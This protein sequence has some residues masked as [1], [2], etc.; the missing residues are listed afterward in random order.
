MAAL[1]AHTPGCKD[2]HTVVYI[3]VHANFSQVEHTI[4]FVQSYRTKLFLYDF[5]PTSGKE[6]LIAFYRSLALPDGCECSLLN[7]GVHELITELVG[8]WPK[9]VVI[10]L[11][12][13]PNY[14]FGRTQVLFFT[15]LQRAYPDL[16]K[17]VYVVGHCI[18]GCE[19]CQTSDKHGKTAFFS[20][21]VRGELPLKASS[22]IDT[23]VRIKPA[24][25][26][27]SLKRVLLAPSYGTT[28]ILSN[29]AVAEALVTATQR[30]ADVAVLAKFHGV[31]YAGRAHPLFQLSS[32]EYDTAALLQRSFVTVGEEAF[33][34]LPFME[35]SHLLI[36]DLNS[37]VP[38]EGLFFAESMIVFAYAPPPPYRPPVDA[39]YHA[40]LHIFRTP[41]ELV[42]LLAAFASGQLN[43]SPRGRAFFEQKKGLMSGNE[44]ADIAAQRGWH[45]SYAGP[46]PDA[47]RL[48]CIPRDGAVY[49][50]AI[51]PDE[52]T[53]STV[54]FA[55][56]GLEIPDSM[57]PY[58]QFLLAHQI[59]LEAGGVP[60]ELWHRVFA[61]ISQETFDAGTCFTLGAYSDGSG[62]LV[63]CTAPNGIARH[64]D[65]WLI[66]HAWTTTAER[67]RQVLEGNVPLQ[68]RLAQMMSLEPQTDAD[69]ARAGLVDRLVSDG[70]WRHAQTYTMRSSDG[71]AQPVW[72][73]MDELGSALEHCTDDPAV[74]VMPFLYLDK[75]LAYSLM[76]PRRA[77]ALGEEVTRD[78]CP[79]TA[80]DPLAHAANLLAWF[81]I[82][83]LAAGDD[84]LAAGAAY[85]ERLDAA[86][87]QAQL[88]G[89]AAPGAPLTV[90]DESTGFGSAESA[91]TGLKVC[92]PL[93][94]IRDHMSHARIGAFTD[95]WV[96]ADLI[97]LP[98]D[99]RF[100]ALL[101]P[102][103]RV[104]QFPHEACLTVKNRLAALVGHTRGSNVPW[105]P[106]SYDLETD[107]AA[108]CADYL[109]RAAAGRDNTWIVK[110][111]NLGRSEDMFVTRSLARILRSM[112]TV[113]R[114]VC[115]YIER[116][117]LYDGRKF[118]MRY[119]VVVRRFEPLEAYVYN[120]FWLRLANE[121][122]ALEDFA[123][124]ERHFTVMNYT[125]H[126]RLTQLLYR[127][128]VARWDSVL[129][130]AHPWYSHMQPQVNAC[131]RQ[132]F[133]SAASVPPP[134][135]L[136]GHGSNPHCAAM[137]GM[138]VMIEISD[139]GDIMRPVLLECNF[140]P[141]CTRAV[142]PIYAPTFF[143]DLLAVMFLERDANPDAWARV[144]AI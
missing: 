10:C 9:R 69:G 3:P 132:L 46:A 120:M 82:D 123:N 28:S 80:A 75:A 119:I 97:W 60:Q 33:N 21:Y 15:H 136:R 100:F 35:A 142:M 38:F 92:T 93:Q 113:P 126:G 34:I 111:W 4:E 68:Q 121:Q 40:H 73:V 63:Q 98:T 8:E 22:V 125:G 99:F 12:A 39:E 43:P 44:A 70:F 58:V 17:D 66:D 16:I 114:L 37:S 96:T 19:S 103:Q 85:R 130:P 76:W 137:Y 57:G 13:S 42:E 52:H 26:P 62:F 14:E 55:A 56:L 29:P 88:P 20:R 7:F 2:P 30:L 72:Y 116:P 122:F 24:V 81:P 91:R 127:D 71:S 115:K 109:A 129:Y 27:A 41:D 124:Y 78:F 101:Q 36:T 25:P 105:L 79:K 107:L 51:A 89:P 23:Y 45:A 32:I 128:F 67:A 18:Y 106:A 5:L 65:V 59:Q 131:F 6:A 1:A 94:L 87:R 90:A 133:E 135:G 53:R 117:A 141:D 74:C 143:N 49:L 84:V 47:E 61:K 11:T 54:T 102:W 118:D 31:I 112:E 50:Q 95:D 64:G 83:E 77:I 134:L 144:T 110:A 138:D 140:A 139:N 48:R 104:N 108:F 86:A